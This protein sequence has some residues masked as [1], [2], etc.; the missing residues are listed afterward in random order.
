MDSKKRRLKSATDDFIK[1]PEYVMLHNEF[2]DSLVDKG[3]NL[4]DAIATTDSVFRNL[5]MKDTYEE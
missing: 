3:C 2:C 5:K 4:E 1:D